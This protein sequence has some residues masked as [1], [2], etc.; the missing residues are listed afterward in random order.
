MREFQIEEKLEKELTKISKKNPVMHEIIFK[1]MR[2]IL[3]CPDVNHYKN[4]RSPLQEFKRVHIKG[5][6]VLI[7]KYLP[8]EDKILFYDIDHHDVI[9]Q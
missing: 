5:S 9:Y 3:D 7:F 2:E 4:L 8:S 6:S 1:K